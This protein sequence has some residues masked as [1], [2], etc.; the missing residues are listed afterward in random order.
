MDQT[1]VLHF[2]NVKP[3]FKLMIIMEMITE[4]TRI[5]KATTKISNKIEALRIGA[6]FKAKFPNQL[7]YSTSS[8][9][10]CFCGELWPN[11]YLFYCYFF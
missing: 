8:C 5:I 9:F 2:H 11:Y 7:L 3:I 1:R 6:H 10:F 4:N